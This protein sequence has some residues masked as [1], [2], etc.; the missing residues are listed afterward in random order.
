MRQVPGM[1]WDLMGHPSPCPPT[2]A[3]LTTAVSPLPS[4]SRRAPL[5]LRLARLRQEV[6]ALRRV[7]PPSPDAHGGEALSLPALLQALHPQ[8]PPDQARTPPPRLPPGTAAAPWRSQHLAQRLTA[9][10]PGWQP[11]AQPR[12]QPGP[13]W[14]VGPSPAPLGAPAT[15]LLSRPQGGHR[16][17][18]AWP[19]PAFL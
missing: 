18:A 1:H 13:R 12:A 8:R 9:L 3:P 7:G 17:T 2:S 4:P 19:L 6:C 16:L 10:Q 14:P 15:G 5:C 11:S